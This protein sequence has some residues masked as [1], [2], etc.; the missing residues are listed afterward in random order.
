MIIISRFTIPVIT[1]AKG[2]LTNNL[3]CKNGIEN[4]DRAEISMLMIFDSK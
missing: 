3:E 2:V 4:I 1:L